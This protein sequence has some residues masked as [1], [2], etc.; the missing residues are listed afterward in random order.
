MQDNNLENKYRVEV[1]SMGDIKVESDKYWGAQTQRSL[2]NFKI[3]DQ[4]Q[5]LELIYAFAELKK[6]CAV[7]NADLGLLDREIAEAIANSVDQITKGK[8]DDN[9]PLVVWQTGSG[10]QTN[11]NLNE[12]IANKAIEQLNGV[13]GSKDPVHPNDHVNKGQSSNDTYPTAMHIASLVAIEEKLLPELKEFYESLAK[14][15]DDFA[16]IAKIGRTHMQDAT[17]IT[18]GDEF[19]GYAFQIKDNIDRLESV[20]SQLRTL[21]IG[22]TAVGTGL[23]THV[24]FDA[25][26]CQELSANLGTKFVPA[27]NKF[28]QMAANDALVNVSGVLKTIAVSLMSIANNIRMLASGPRCGIGEIILPSNE[29]GSSIMPGK[30]NPTQ[31]EALTM[32]AAE[33]MGNDVTVGI[34]GSNGHFQLN[35]FKPVIIFKVLESINLLADGMTSFRTKCLDGIEPNLEKIKYNLEN[36]LML[37]TALNPH[38][39]YDNAAKIA[40]HAHQNNMSLKQAGSELGI[41][42]AEDFDKFVKVENMLRKDK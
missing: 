3:G 27:E 32:V 10:T 11:M 33:V 37:V 21:A 34:A 39:G 1:D 12:V 14:K 9:F 2:E 17:P 7:V 31:A 29:P 35:V 28:S 25:R 36:S 26:V 38:I 42:S 8:L 40:K 5:P 18:L 30:V 23:N 4:K 41:I 22:G 6:A 15:E 19:S 13:V 24:E 16:E 20:I